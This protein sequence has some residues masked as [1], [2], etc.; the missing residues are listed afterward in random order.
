MNM[1]LVKQ[2]KKRKRRV[3]RKTNLVGWNTAGFRKC[4]NGRKILKIGRRKQN[5]DEMKCFG[6]R[7][8]GTRKE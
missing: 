5:H 2:K 4:I 6:K 7:R 1:P 8:E 3:D